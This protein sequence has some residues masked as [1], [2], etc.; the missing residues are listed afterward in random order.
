MRTGILRVVLLCLCASSAPLLGYGEGSE[1]ASVRANEAAAR[2]DL[3]DKTS[4]FSIDLTANALQ[5]LPATLS[6]KVLAPDDKLLAEASVAVRLS[7]IPTRA[8]VPILWVPD[9]GLDHVSSCRLFYEVRLEG[10]SSAA[11]SGILSP[12]ALIPDLFELHFLGLDAV[13][14]GH[15]YVARVW[16]TRPDSDKPMPGV[17]LTAFI[18]DDETD[19]PK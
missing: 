16:A 12:Y 15:S 9:S 7:S 6:V 4:V 17:S 14:L 18:G 2:L 5:I 19:T 10:A 3:K 13:G 1:V 11:A 8:E